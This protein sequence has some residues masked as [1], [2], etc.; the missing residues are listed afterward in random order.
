MPPIP[1]ALHNRPATTATADGRLAMS[2][3]PYQAP[4]LSKLLGDS[5]I[6]ELFSVRAELAAMLR[7][8]AELAKAQASLE[9]I[10]AGAGAAISKACAS[11]RPDIDAIGAGAS[12]DGVA[13]PEL[14]RQLRAAIGEPFAAYCHFGATSQDVVDTALSIRL[15][16]VIAI[17]RARIDAVDQSLDLLV[18]RFGANPLMARTRMQSALPV[19]VAHRLGN[20]EAP[21]DRFGGLLPQ[22]EV[23]VAQL[24]LGGPVGDLA[25]FGEKGTQLCRMVATSLD[26]AVP[27]RPWHTDRSAIVEF[28]DWMTRLAGVLGKIGMDIALMAQNGIEEVRLSGTGGSSA[29]AHK[30]NPVLAEA[31]VTLARFTAV[32][33]TGM[34]L[35][36]VHE[37][38][39]SGSAWALEWMLLP[40][41]CVASGAALRNTVT[42]L[43]AVE[44]MG[45]PGK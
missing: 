21:V 3:T 4:I 38:E 36:Q 20:W 30:Q 1:V 2:Y 10:P 41:L 15:K 8:E 39:R 28:C 11:F 40:Q 22:L 26:L 27:D 35:S 32:L 42:L 31:L 43:N 19:S 5:E 18:E 29:M 16:E 13:V 17:F 24:Q 37:Q 45:T 6:A 25:Q 12:V 14:I 44:A 7:F 9:M 23:R 34:H 33:D